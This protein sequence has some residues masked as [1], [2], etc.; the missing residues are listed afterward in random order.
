[1]SVF[2]LKIMGKTASFQVKVQCAVVI[3][4]IITNS[5]AQARQ[6]T[7]AGWA[8]VYSRP[9]PL[10]ELTDPIKPSL[11]TGLGVH[12]HQKRVKLKVESDR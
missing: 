9:C 1:L 11:A 8:K 3:P 5:V 6:I 12:L 4:V 7:V 10:C 2:E